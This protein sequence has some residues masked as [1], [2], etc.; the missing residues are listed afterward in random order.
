MILQGVETRGSEF[1]PYTAG[2]VTI[3]KCGIF[4]LFCSWGSGNF[5]A[6][7]LGGRGSGIRTPVRFLRR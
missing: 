7:R 5:S 4:G 2:R 3:A 6:S 1:L